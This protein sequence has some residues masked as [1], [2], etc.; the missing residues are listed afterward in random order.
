M[1]ANREHRGIQQLA[2][3]DQATADVAAGALLGSVTGLAT[4][5]LF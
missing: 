3:A 4:G 2:L 1:E 5:L